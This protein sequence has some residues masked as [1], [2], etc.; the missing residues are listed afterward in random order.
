MSKKLTYGDL[1]KAQE[2]KTRSLTPEMKEHVW[3]WVDIKR[4]NLPKMT[5]TESPFPSTGF[6]RE[7]R[8][9]F[10]PPET[11]NVQKIN[12]ELPQ[13][14]GLS[15]KKYIDHDGREHSVL[16][17]TNEQGELVSCIEITG[18]D[19]THPGMYREGGFDVDKTK[20][21]KTISDFYYAVL[22]SN[23]TP[24]NFKIEGEEIEINTNGLVFLIHQQPSDEYPKGR[25]ALTMWQEHMATTSNNDYSLLRSPGQGSIQALKNPHHPISTI[26]KALGGDKFRNAVQNGTYPIVPHQQM[27]PDR[28]GNQHNL[29]P[30]GVTVTQEQADKI[31]K[32]S[33]DTIRFFAPLEIDA[34]IAAGVVN[35]HTITLWGEYK[36]RKKIEQIQE[37]KAVGT[38]APMKNYFKPGFFNIFRSTKR[39]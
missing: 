5:V 38:I 8:A 33:Q 25:V 10:I 29:T 39:A 15:I 2:E 3:N 7:Y 35:A 11:L 30:T 27:D 31:E 34:L 18:G 13:V 24:Q 23:L 20:D 26:V 6:T 14:K 37:K 4:A 32:E 1:L 17:H 21:G 36:A 16:I 28:Q 22:E 9:H 19:L 12:I